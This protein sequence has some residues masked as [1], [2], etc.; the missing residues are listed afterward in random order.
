MLETNHGEPPMLKKLNT[1]ETARAKPAAFI[2]DDPFRLED[3]L[4]EEE[5]MIRDAARD[6]CQDRL[7][8]LVLLD[9]RASVV[10]LVSNHQHVHHRPPSSATT[11]VLQSA[12]IS[13][14]R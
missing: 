12:R 8:S 2:W 11:T 3:E 4:T 1:P 6:Y 10:S 13:Q 14:N 9:L 7:A 5:R